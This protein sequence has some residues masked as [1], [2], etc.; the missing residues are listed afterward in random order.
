[1]LKSLASNEESE[2][3]I[4]KLKNLQIIQYKKQR[5]YTGI[6]VA[7][8]IISLGVL[9]WYRVRKFYHLEFEKQK[10]YFEKQNAIEEE[11]TR[12]AQELH[13]GLG[14]MLSGIK[15]SFSAMQNQMQLSDSQQTV[16]HTNIDKLNESINE[17]RNISHSIASDSLSKYGLENT[18]RDYCNS[19]NE[20]GIL[21]ISFKAIDTANIFLTEQQ[22]FHIYRIVQELLQN[23]I[24]HAE[25]AEA[26]VQ[27]NYNEKYLYVTVE[28]NGKGFELNGEENKRGIGLKNIESRVK[29]LK[30]KLDY[31]TDPSQGTSVLIEIRCSK[32]QV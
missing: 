25:A 27:M 23:I 24:K 9:A 5:V 8:I 20:P 26:L 28:D 11:R 15:H 7:L 17:L 22:T 18:L 31:R 29:I 10:S 21:N 1:M 12:M 16:F 32:K 13:D 6:I 3:E 14:S 4:F 2:N 30:G 19:L